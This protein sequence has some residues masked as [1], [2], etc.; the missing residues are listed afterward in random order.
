MGLNEGDSLGGVVGLE[1][2]RDVGLDDVGTSMRG[3]VGTSDE[4]PVGMV[5]GALHEVEEG[6]WLGAAVGLPL[7][8]PVGD[9]DGDK[10]GVFVGLSVGPL[11]GDEDP[12]LDAEIVAGLLLSIGPFGT[13]NFLESEPM[14]IS[15]EFPS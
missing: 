13:M 15:V 9:S 2:G 10:V 8:I 11:E 1:L 14:V 12:L 7:G 4:L 5:L 3:Q 6:D